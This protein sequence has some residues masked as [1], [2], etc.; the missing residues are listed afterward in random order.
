MK[1]GKNKATKLPKKI[2]GVKVPKT[3]RKKG[4]KV[5]DALSHPLVADIAAAALLAAAAALRDNKK[6]RAAAV[7]AKDEAG[8]AASGVAG[9]AD[10]LG[11]LIAAKAAKTAREFGKAYAVAEAADD[12][13]KSEGADKKKKSGDKSKARKSGK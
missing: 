3:L 6:V 10:S 11:T 7:T 5:V 1:M 12:E 8:D 2:A 13:G 9:G 4:G